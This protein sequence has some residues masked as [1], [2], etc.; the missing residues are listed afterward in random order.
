MARVEPI[1][2]NSYCKTLR[3]THIFVIQSINLS[4]RYRHYVD[5]WVFNNGTNT[6][7]NFKRLY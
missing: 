5:A 7:H 1:S 3:I 6:L 4:T 2:Q